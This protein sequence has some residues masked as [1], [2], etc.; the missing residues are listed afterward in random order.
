MSR[1]GGRLQFFVGVRVLLAGY[2]RTV[3]GGPSFSDKELFAHPTFEP[4]PAQPDW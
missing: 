1:S 4:T 2:N 3:S